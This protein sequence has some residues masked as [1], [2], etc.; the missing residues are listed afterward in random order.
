MIGRE[1]KLGRTRHGLSQ[2]ALGRPIGFSGSKVGRIERGQAPK[3][4]VADAIL[5][6]ASVGLDLPVSRVPGRRCGGGQF[7][8]EPDPVREPDR[9]GH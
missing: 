8:R 2:D 4:T 5:L 7:Q 6:L 3:L 9:R 1:I